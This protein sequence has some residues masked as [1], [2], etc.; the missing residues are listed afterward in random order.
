VR[1]F[2]HGQSA[3]VKL[4]GS[5]SL[6]PATVENILMDGQS[7]PRIGFPEWL[8]KDHSLGSVTFLVE[9]ELDPNAIGLPAEV[10]VTDRLPLMQTVK[11]LAGY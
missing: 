7:R 4:A 1:S 8:R 11:R 9:Q 10:F 3:F 2:A 6:I 5:N